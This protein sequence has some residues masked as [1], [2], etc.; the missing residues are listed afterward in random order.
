MKTK[1]CDLLNTK[2]PILQGAMAWVGTAELA[3][4]VSNAGGMGIISP[5]TGRRLDKEIKLA[6]E[7]TDKPFGVNITI[8]AP[9]SEEVVKEVV[10]EGIG[11]VTTSVGSPKKFTKTLQNRGVKVIHSVAKVEHAKKANEAGVD[12]VI[13]QGV[14]AGGHPGPDEITTFT[15]VPQVVD[16]VDIPVIAAGGIGDAR[17][18]AAALMLGAEGVQIGTRFIA[19]KECIAHEKFKRAILN[20]EDTDTVL[21]GRDEIFPTRVLRNKF[22]ESGKKI[23]LGM[24]RA[25]TALIEGDLE[26]GVMMCGQIAGMIKDIRSVEEVVKELARFEDLMR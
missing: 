14:E 17:G 2:Y 24:K 19:T 6:K 18:V 13:V 10:R 5:L 23:G 4:A 1:I 7:L 8:M 16:A 9:D 22:V 3:S 26:N 21:V 11:T 15:L 20:S 12:A 25:K